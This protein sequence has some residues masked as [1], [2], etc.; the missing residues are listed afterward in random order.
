MKTETAYALAELDN[1]A[2]QVRNVGFDLIGFQDTEQDSPYSYEIK[3]ALE[4]QRKLYDAVV[5]IYNMYRN[6]DA[7]EY[8]AELGILEP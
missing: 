7:R 5:D 4:L 6:K 2:K 3:N 1:I 8:E